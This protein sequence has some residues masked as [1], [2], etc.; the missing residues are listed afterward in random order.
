MFGIDV[1]AQKIL[2]LTACI[3]FGAIMKRLGKLDGSFAAGCSQVIVY[4]SQPAMIIYGF[5]EAD[6]SMEVLKISAAVFVFAFLFHLMYYGI[7]LLFFKNAPEKKQTILRFATMFTNAGFLGM[8]IISELISPVAAVYATFYVVAFNILNWSVGC[9]MFTKDKKYVTPIKM[10]INPATVPTYI[11]LALF[12]ICGVVK[13]P[14]AATPFV[15]F[16]SVVFKDNIL[17]ILKS[18]VIPLCMFMVG[19]RLA[20]CDFKTALKDKYIP[21][22][23]FIRLI[24]LPFIVMGVMKLVVLSGIF[25]ESIIIP[26]SYVLV[27][28]SSTPAAAMASIFAEYFDGDKAYAGLIVSVS[29]VCSLI[30]MSIVA[31]TLSVVF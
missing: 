6:F 10:F 25:P 13:V 1:L 29:S 18:T 21:L 8:P 7:S 4:V 9:Y 27:I 26:T 17:F 14:D 3:V 28:S 2:L 23:L 16:I 30:T 20:D 22:Q 24:V 15:S 31:V 19:I 12:V 5:V 11:G